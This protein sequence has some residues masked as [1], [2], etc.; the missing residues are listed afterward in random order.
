MAEINKKN[1]MATSHFTD[2][3]Q[4]RIQELPGAV[5]YGETALPISPTEVGFDDQLRSDLS[6]MKEAN[7]NREESEQFIATRGLIG[8]W[9]LAEV[10]LRAWVE[11]IKWKGSDQMRSHLGIPLVAEEFYSI[12]SVVNQTLFGGYQSFKI[13]ATSGTPLAC[14][15]AQQA[16]INAQ[17]K[18]CGY[19]GV[20]CKT[21]MRE[22]TYDGL[23]YGF[24]VAH[25]GWSKLS[26]PI[27]KKVQ[28]QHPQTMVVNGNVV[29]VPQFDE[30]DVEDKVVGTLEI[31]MPKLEHVPIRRA[32]YAPDL[33]R[34]D[35]RCAEW[36]GRILYCTGYDLDAQRKVKGWKIPSREELVKLSTPQMQSMAATN[37]LET[38]GSNTGN[39]VFQQTT[40]PQKAY[41]ENYTERTAHDPLMRKFE[42]FDYWTG[43]RHCIILGKELCILNDTHKFGRPPFLGFC[44]RNA[45]DSAHGYGIAFWLTDFQR[46]CQGIINAFLDDMNLNLMGTYTAPAGTNNTA[47]AQWIFPGKVFKHDPNGEFKPLT[48]NAISANEPL[49]VI[50]QMK[51]WAAA[52]AG[53]GPSTLGGNT[54]SAGA[55]RT[56][57]GV[58][59]VTSGENVKLQDLVDVIS[60]QIYIPF[61]EYCVEENQKLKPSQ[62][63]TMLSDALGLAFQATPLDIINGTYRVDISAGARLASREALNKTIGILQTLIQ[64]PGTVENLGVQAMKIDFNGMMTMLFDAFGGPY[65]EKIIVPMND[66][67]KARMAAN[68]QQ[69]AMQGKLG[70][71]K[72]QGE[73]KKDVDNNQSENRM[74]LET[75]K[76]TLKAQGVDHQASVDAASAKAEAATPEAQGLDRA[77]KGAFAK[78]DSSAF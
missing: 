65:K 14:A 33:R 38:L 11:P 63:R 40:T 44:F 31:N 75:G 19:K 53:A 17:L 77:A 49:Q 66:D 57:G 27:I 43:S 9:N 16:I 34:G 30:D 67:D 59:A 47:Q 60:E 25:Y 41:P 10:M 18:T 6:M 22:I 39:P 48:R 64:S 37:P 20:S 7:L 61:L 4:I 62:V 73:V 70:I 28:K 15:E 74:L 69:A 78:M 76:H 42:L 23:F 29:N 13:D 54:G 55:M 51:Q 2:T 52:V 50:A 1:P 46:I 8:R 71:V 3:G 72:A 35:P 58:E 68:T 45:P 12:H 32:R 5:P 56:P 21:E 26:K 24:G 36:F